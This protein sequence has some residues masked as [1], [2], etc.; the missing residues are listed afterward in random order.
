MSKLLNVFAAQTS[1]TTNNVRNVPV[2]PVCTAGPSS[3]SIDTKS[4]T[5]YLKTER[6]IRTSVTFSTSVW[7]SEEEANAAHGDV[8]DYVK[9]QSFRQLAEEVFGEFRP[10]FQEIRQTIRALHVG[11]SDWDFM[12]NMRKLS[13]QLDEMEQQMFNAEPPPPEKIPPSLRTFLSPPQ[14]GISE[15]PAK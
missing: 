10:R 7:V 2:R 8:I 9:R 3:S 15:S 6:G 4:M 14:H 5:Y 13:Q 11:W 12:Q 1:Y